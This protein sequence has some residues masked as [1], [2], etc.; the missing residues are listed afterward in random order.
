MNKKILRKHCSCTMLQNLVHTL[1]HKHTEWTD[2]AAF[3]CS[4]YDCSC[5]D[6]HVSEISTST[7]NASA[8]KLQQTTTFSSK[9]YNWLCHHHFTTVSPQLFCN[10]RFK[11]VWL[12]QGP[13]PHRHL[14]SFFTN[15]H[16]TL[17]RQSV[18]R[19]PIYLHHRSE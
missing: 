17:A 5:D 12:K 18:F 4:G 15:S 7:Y 19:N 14:Q 13:R 2:F 1:I 6:V 9:Y 8:M 16:L 10:C 3:T 11:H